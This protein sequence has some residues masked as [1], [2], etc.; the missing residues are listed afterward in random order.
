MRVPAGECR[1]AVPEIA[2]DIVAEERRGG[3]EREPEHD[4]QSQDQEAH[5]VTRRGGAFSEVP[6]RAGR[7]EGE[8]YGE[9]IE[10]EHG[11]EQDQEGNRPA[12]T[13]P[14][15]EHGQKGALDAY[16]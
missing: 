6:V 7:S 5:A 2:I 16:A 3:Q 11:E 10:T 9:E 1:A 13:G 12:G 15:L 8:P 4:G 14:R